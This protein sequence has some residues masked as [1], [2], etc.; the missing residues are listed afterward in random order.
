MASAAVAR[1]V[2]QV[3]RVRESGRH[4]GR[5]GARS[6]KL[7][8]AVELPGLDG[9]GATVGVGSVWHACRSFCQPLAVVDRGRA[10]SSPFGGDR[11][12]WDRAERSAI[13][14]PGDVVW[15]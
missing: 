7:A 4:S 13:G 9:A 14:D 3:V 15:C 5:S 8:A 12:P 11:L 2:R 6:W 1:V 10:F